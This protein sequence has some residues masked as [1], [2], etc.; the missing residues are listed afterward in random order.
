M[1]LPLHSRRNLRERGTNWAAIAAGVGSGEPPIAPKEGRGRGTLHSPPVRRAGCRES[2]VAVPRSASAPTHTIVM[3][4]R[5]VFRLVLTVIREVLA[6]CCLLAVL[7]IVE[8]DL[9][10]IVVVL[11]IVI[12]SLVVVLGPEMDDLDG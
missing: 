4:A 12:V 11:R 10:V 3:P 8:A 6:V 7:V 9:E 1:I 2:T 5:L